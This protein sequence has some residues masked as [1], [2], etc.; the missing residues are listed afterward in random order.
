MEAS[1]ATLGSVFGTYMRFYQ[2]TYLPMLV[3][4]SRR[5][6]STRSNFHLRLLYLFTINALANRV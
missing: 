1:S 3:I 6:A 2:L 5:E 4:Y